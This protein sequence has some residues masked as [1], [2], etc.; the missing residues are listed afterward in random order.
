MSSFKDP[1]YQDRIA[2][3]AA[4]KQNALDQ[5]K[6][7]PAADPAAMAER[8]AMRA[9]R[10]AGQAAKRAAARSAKAEAAAQDAAAKAAAAGPTDEERKQ[11][12]DARYAARKSRK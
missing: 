12:R 7:R 5:L 11:A 2:R 4:A 8:K 3:A 6:A 1:T 9:A 10:E